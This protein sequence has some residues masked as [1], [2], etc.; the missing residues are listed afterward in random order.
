M[1]VVKKVKIVTANA[2][3]GEGW[4]DYEV[5]EADDY[6]HLQASHDRLLTALNNVVDGNDLA[7]SRQQTLHGWPE[8][9]FRK[10]ARAAIAEATPEG[11]K[12]GTK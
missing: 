2:N 11:P 12:E 5:V 10:Q 9:T 1:R 4:Y 7:H 6:K 3:F 8:S